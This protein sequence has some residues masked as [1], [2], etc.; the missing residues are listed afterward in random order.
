MKT[1]LEF[2]GKISELFLL[3][4][5]ED[6]FMFGKDRTVEKKE[7]NLCVRSK[8][9]ETHVKKNLD[10]TFSK[11]KKNQRYESSE[12]RHSTKKR[13]EGNKKKRKETKKM[14][15]LERSGL[16]PNGED[17]EPNKLRKKYL[18]YHC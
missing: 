13:N 14:L 3:S 16:N 11:K 17:Y 18:F 1:K 12:G 8:K 4:D 10:I 2:L 7:D 6:I 15:V 5:E 9:T